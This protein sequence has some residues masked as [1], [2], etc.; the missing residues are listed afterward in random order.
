MTE[1]HPAPVELSTLARQF[2]LSLHGNARQAISAVGTL[3]AAGP[4][5]ISFFANAAY[6]DELKKTQAGAVILKAEDAADCPVSYLVASDPYL[7]YARIASLFDQ[8]PRP[9]AGIHPAASVHP[10]ARLG[11]GVSVAAGAV[12]EAGCDIGA[13]CSI[14]PGCTVGANSRIGANSRLVANVSICDGVRIGQRAIIHPGAVIGADG[15]GIAHNGSGWE[16]VP[17]L[18]SVVIGDDCEVGANSCIDRG[19]IGDTV[20]EDDVRIDNLCQVGH[21]CHIGAHTAMAAFTG[22]AGSTRIGKGCLFAGR[23]GAHGHLEIA[24]RVTVSAMTMV[25]KSITEP[26]TVWSAGIPAQPIREW[27]KIVAQLRRLDQTI[28]RLQKPNKN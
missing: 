22:I 5:D 4:G 26:G 14:G 7:A 27:Q 15:F 24:D 11:E 28:R 2:D 6:R 17:Q 18:G 1:T 3:A 9:A 13:G 23:S 25:K 20:L 10:R 19:A 8:R 16:K 21:N 12:I